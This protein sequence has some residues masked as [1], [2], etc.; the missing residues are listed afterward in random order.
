[1]RYF[2]AAVVAGAFGCGDDGFTPTL[3]EPW[4]P[5]K[6]VASS[7]CTEGC[8][9]VA[10]INGGHAGD[11]VILADPRRDDP[12]RQWQQCF[13]SFYACWQEGGTLPAC[14]ATSTCPAPCRDELARRI[15]GAVGLEAEIA[16]Y[17]AVFVDA[18][19]PCRDPGP[20]HEETP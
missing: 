14:V 12:R 4:R 19:A 8:V 10:E 15:D 11:L 16:A 6:A 7:D 20:P 1:M 17:R 13:L 9:E 5:G 18:S 2:V 3:A